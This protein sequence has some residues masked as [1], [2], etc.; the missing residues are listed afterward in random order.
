MDIASGI[1]YSGKYNT[2]IPI[3]PPSAGLAKRA[4]GDIIIIGGPQT[5]CNYDGLGDANGLGYGNGR[6]GIHAAQYQKE[7]P[8]D[9]ASHYHLNVT[10][11][12]NDGNNIGGLTEADAPATQAVN[13]YSRLP[14]VIPVT[15]Q[16]FDDVGLWEPELGLCRCSSS[17]QFWGL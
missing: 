5:D 11:H 17:I 7:N 3:Q 2:H 4:P 1:N 10:L 16:Q 15:Y 13:V 9:P 6:C 12:D 8:N 14:P